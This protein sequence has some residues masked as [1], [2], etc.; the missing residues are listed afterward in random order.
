[1]GDTSSHGHLGVRLLI[2]LYALGIVAIGAY[3]I[4]KQYGGIVEFL[5]Q[6]TFGLSQAKIPYVRARMGTGGG[7]LKSLDLPSRDLPD[8]REGTVE[9]GRAGRAE[10]VDEITGKDRKALNKL[11]DGL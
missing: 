2:I 11:I 6:Q 4:Q 10:R 7:V 5:K 3:P 8:I 9:T 1:M